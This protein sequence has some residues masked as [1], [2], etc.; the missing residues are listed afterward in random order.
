MRLYLDQDTCAF[1]LTPYFESRKMLILP[2]EVYVQRMGAKLDDEHFFVLQ[3]A[4]S[5]LCLAREL[6]DAPGWYTLVPRP[7]AVSPGSAL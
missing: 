1:F 6:H 4:P 2:K 5:M 7:A 3:N